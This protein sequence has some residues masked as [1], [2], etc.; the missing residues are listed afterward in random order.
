[1]TEEQ[2]R[3]KHKGKCSYVSREKELNELV[4]DAYSLV[5]NEKIQISEDGVNDTSIAY[6]YIRLNI[7]DGEREHTHHCLTQTDESDLKKAAEEYAKTFWC[8]EDDYEGEE[9]NGGS[10]WEDN[11]SY[12][13]HG[14]EI[15]VQL[16]NWRKITKEEFHKLGDFFYT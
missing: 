7:R 1:M 2:F 10:S 3:D 13:M 5:K 8:N 6:L 4:T 9:G 14:G 16:K 12:Y 11:G 15:C